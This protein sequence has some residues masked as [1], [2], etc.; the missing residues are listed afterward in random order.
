MNSL[1]LDALRCALKNQQVTWQQEI[2][3]AQWEQLFELSRT[4]RVLPMIY[5]AV[6][7]CPSA[8]RADKLFSPPSE[9]RYSSRF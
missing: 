7:S 3:T 9:N 8:R 5:N 2:T 4:Q 6:F 1:F